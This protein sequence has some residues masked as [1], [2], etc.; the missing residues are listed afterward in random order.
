MDKEIKNNCQKLFQKD[1]RELGLRL[2]RFDGEKGIV[3]CNHREK[4]NI[5]TLL[6]SIKNINIK[7]VGTSGTIKALQRKHLGKK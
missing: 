1:C 5:I 3:K 4:D 6:N 7:T 2:I